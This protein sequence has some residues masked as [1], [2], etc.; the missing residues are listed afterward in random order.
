MAVTSSHHMHRKLYLPLEASRAYHQP[1]HQKGRRYGGIA[2]SSGEV[3]GS[4]G[5]IGSRGIA[6]EFPK[7]IPL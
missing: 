6:E 7:N 4:T 3:L 2:R 5:A 1:W